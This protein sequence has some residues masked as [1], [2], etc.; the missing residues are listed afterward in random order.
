MAHFGPHTN[1]VETT[2][3]NPTQKARTLKNAVCPSLLT[4]ELFLSTICLLLSIHVL[5][6]K[7]RGL[8]VAQVYWTKGLLKRLSTVLILTCHLGTSS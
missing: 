1:C 3:E 2:E 4:Y 5:V 8:I 7:V 6:V